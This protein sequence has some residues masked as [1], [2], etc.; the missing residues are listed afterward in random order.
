MQI[1]FKDE[2]KKN[3]RELKLVISNGK[4]QNLQN[5]MNFKITVDGISI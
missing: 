2:D 5:T 3:P 4:D 1:H